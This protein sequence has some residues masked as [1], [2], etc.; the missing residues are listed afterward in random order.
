MTDA[1]KDIKQALKDG[2]LVIGTRETVKLLKQGGIS[3]V[4]VPTNVPAGI[5]KDL[6][7]Y[8][9]LGASELR[10]FEGDS[11]TLAQV[12]GK[13]FKILALGIKK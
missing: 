12:C 1:T 9:G 3:A 13:P 2:K 7:R 10:T 5:R 8:A 6:E 11:V 4:I